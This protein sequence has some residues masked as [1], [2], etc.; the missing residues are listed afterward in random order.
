MHSF[1]FR[2]VVGAL[3]GLTLVLRALVLAPALAQTDD[4]VPADTSAP[5][6]NIVFIMADDLGDEVLGAYGGDSFDTPNIDALAESGTRFTHAFSTPVC[7]PSRATIL[8]GRYTFRYAH[9]WGHLPAGEVTFGNV[10]RDAGYATA[11]AGKWQM[12]LLKDKPLQPRKEGFNRYSFWAWHEGP[13]Y[14]DPL[15]WQDARLVDDAIDHRYGPDVYTDFLIDHI[16]RNRGEH[17]RFFAYFPMTVP[18]LAKTGGPYEEPP[19]L[20]GDYQTYDELVDQMD[21]LVGRIV[22]ALERYGLREETLILFTGDNGTPTH[23]TATVEGDTL[24]GG[25]GKMTNAG[26]HVPLIASWPGHVPSGEVSRA[27]IDFTDFLPTFADLAGAPLPDDRTIDGVS[28]APQLF[29]RDVG[30]RR[31]VYTQW[32]GNRWA[33]TRNWKLYG[34]GTLYHVAEDPQEQRP[35]APGEGGEQAAA[36]RKKLQ[37][38]FDQLGVNDR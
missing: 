32:E 11:A 4:A 6:P 3:I 1:D 16:K 9:E 26:T 13:R 5:S 27:L 28:F 7:S 23:V 30:H 10:M 29:G 25:K 38:A 18:H 21:R 33:R 15:I 24:Q 14:Y 37:R 22:H 19:G 36:A 34:D 2:T 17:Q 20:D 8:T 12:G 35:I 31:W